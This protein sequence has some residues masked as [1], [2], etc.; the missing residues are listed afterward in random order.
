[1]NC[2]QE[3]QAFTLVLFFACAFTKMRDSGVQNVNKTEIK[4]AYVS[5]LH[6]LVLT[7]THTN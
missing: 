7:V 4:R 6:K 1:M 5:A 2:F 3:G